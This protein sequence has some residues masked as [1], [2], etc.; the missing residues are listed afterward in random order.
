MVNNVKQQQIQ[1]GDIVRV[2]RK[3][4]K[5][6]ECMVIKSLLNHGGFYGKVTENK[7]KVS[8]SSWKRYGLKNDG[9]FQVFNE[10]LY[11]KV[12]S[13]TESFSTNIKSLAESINS[14]L[15][16]QT[17]TY[18]RTRLPNNNSYLTFCL[19]ENYG[20]WSISEDKNKSL[21]ESFI[22]SQN[23]ILTADQE[24]GEGQ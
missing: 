23:S 22:L 5:A 17:A 19:C 20:G 24:E 6:Y 14:N 21:Y 11:I 15:K 8:T 2:T 1:V 16:E 18:Y 12:L 4:G 3:D 10:C 13:K 9:I 7:D